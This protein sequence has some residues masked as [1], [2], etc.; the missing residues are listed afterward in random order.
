MPPGPRKSRPEDWETLRPGHA[1]QRC[2]AA[3]PLVDR[4]AAGA[5][6]D[7]WRA[8]EMLD[9]RRF[10]QVDADFPAAAGESSQSARPGDATARENDSICLSG[11]ASPSST[12]PSSPTSRRTSEWLDELLRRQAVALESPLQGRPARARW[13]PDIPPEKPWAS[14]LQETRT[15]AASPARRQMPEEATPMQESLSAE[16]PDVTRGLAAGRLPRATSMERRAPGLQPGAPVVTLT[17]D[18]AKWVPRWY[19]R[20]A[21]LSAESG[22]CHALGAGTPWSATSG[23]FRLPIPD[24][25]AM[26]GRMNSLAARWC[27]SL[28][29]HSRVWDAAA[30]LLE[31]DDSGASSHGSTEEMFSARSSASWLRSSP[32]AEDPPGA[33]APDTLRPAR[34]DTDDGLSHGSSGHLD[35]S[36]HDSASA[37]S[38]AKGGSGKGALSSGCIPSPASNLSGV[39]CSGEE[40]TDQ[41]EVTV[42]GQAWSYQA[43]SEDGGDESSTASSP[44]QSGQGSRTGETLPWSP[45]S[46][47]ASLKDQGIG[48]SVEQAC[49]EVEKAMACSILESGRFRSAYGNLK[50]A[51]SSAGGIQ[52]ERLSALLAREEESI[53]RRYGRTRWQSINMVH[54]VNSGWDA[55]KRSARN[56]QLQW[57][58]DEQASLAARAAGVFAPAADSLSR[59]SSS[60][61]SSVGRWARS[62][63]VSKKHQAGRAPSMQWSP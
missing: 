51:M 6:A 47:A 33:E 7:T 25:A 32:A 14:P 50:E 30:A 8:K 59:S 5:G 1:G 19:L 3:K 54:D 15:T 55:K 20:G 61:L 53:R 28:D 42:S 35:L 27:S 62:R 40:I 26:S 4:S 63:F 21:V 31:H 56:H 48:L 43:E 13:V 58:K 23:S 39:P 52:I 45:A 18:Q 22:A 16:L 12:P 29:Q 36:S 49:T 9:V 24:A 38:A 37:A 11:P 57:I 60:G 41:V 10:R 17:E 2:Q 46:S 34:T 44:P